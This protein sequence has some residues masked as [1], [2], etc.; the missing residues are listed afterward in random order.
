MIPWLLPTVLIAL[1]LIHTFSRPQWFMF[2]Q[3][4][5]GTMGIMVV[6]YLILRIPF[7]L[8]LTKS[9]FFS[10]DNTLEDAAK[11]L[12][13]RPLYTFFKIVLPV[14][15]PS[16]L[17]VFALNFNFLLT[18]FDMSMFLFHPLAVPLGVEMQNLTVDGA[19]DNLAITFVYSVL[20]MIVAGIVL[21]VVYGRASRGKA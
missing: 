17:A 13:G 12:G 18:E 8:R 15:L 16:V 11:S 14:V 9:A 5:T 1:G 7:T 20:T 10:V 19:S 3:A 21:Y 4:L 6:G 2:N